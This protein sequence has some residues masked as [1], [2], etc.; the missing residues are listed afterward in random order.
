VIRALMVSI[1]GAVIVTRGSSDGT[2]FALG[3]AAVFFPVKSFVNSAK[4]TGNGQ[5]SFS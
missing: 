5:E 2:I 1:S 3:M 4:N